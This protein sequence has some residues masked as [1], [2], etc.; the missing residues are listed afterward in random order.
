MEKNYTPKRSG[1]RKAMI[2]VLVAALIVLAAAAIGIVVIKGQES[3]DAELNREMKEIAEKEEQASTDPTPTPGAAPTAAANSPDIPIDF[4]ALV[5][6]NQ[7]IYAWITVPGTD[8]DYPVVQNPLDDS[9]Y[10]THNIAGQESVEGAIYTEMYNSEDFTDPNTVI[11]GHNMKNGS[12]FASLHQ[13]EDK[14]FFDENREIIIYTP[15]Q[16]LTYRI[17]A[18]YSG[19]NE[20]IMQK[21]DFSDEATFERYIGDIFNIRDMKANI[22]KSVEITA[23]DKILTLST[24]V[25]GQDEK[26]YLVQAVLETDE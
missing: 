21:Y 16:K 14:T 8:I 25:K 9:F 22:D 19:G 2:V 13:Y 17:F 1:K 3:R 26:R 4:S 18:A 11:Y 23:E 24:C 12:M 15:D 6:Q 10:L 7:D 20:H 5:Q